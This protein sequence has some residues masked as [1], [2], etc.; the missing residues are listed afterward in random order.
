MTLEQAYSKMG[1]DYQDVMG[2]LCNESLITKLVIMFLEDESFAELEQALKDKDAEKAFRAAHTLKGVCL[3]L[4]L[5]NLSKPVCE[6]TEA[7]RPMTSLEGTEELLKSVK[8]QYDITVSI[9][10]ELTE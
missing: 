8:E 3:N 10:S 2:R 5:T 4:G 7:L 6:L 1:A 9:I